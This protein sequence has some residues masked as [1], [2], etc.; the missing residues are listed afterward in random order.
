[1][2]DFGLEEGAEEEAELVQPPSLR[3]PPCFQHQQPPCFSPPP[4]PPLARPGQELLPF[5]L[6]QR[7]LEGERW[8]R[9]RDANCQVH[10]TAGQRQERQA[11]LCSQSMDAADFKNGPRLAAQPMPAGA[12]RCRTVRD[13]LHQNNPRRQTHFVARHSFL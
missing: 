11:G 3:P 4:Q 6:K 7:E 13:D 9:G 5:C 2:V 12:R 8:R 1:M 10:S